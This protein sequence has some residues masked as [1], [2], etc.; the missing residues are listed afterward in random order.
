M[1]RM[2]GHLRVL[3]EGVAAKPETAVGR[4]PMLAEAERQQV[5][6]TCSQAATRT[7]DL[8][9]HARFGSRRGGRRRQWRSDPGRQDADVQRVGRE[10]EPTWRTICAGSE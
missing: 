10:G 8:P 3:L 1:R 2:A 6:V 9:V 4:L 5:L 7:A